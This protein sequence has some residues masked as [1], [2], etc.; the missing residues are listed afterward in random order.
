MKK[1][2]QKVKLRMRQVLLSKE[3]LTLKMM[4]VMRKVRQ[5]VKLR[6]I[7]LPWSKEKL[8]L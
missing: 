1:V 7:Q 5:K 4:K 3:K 6:M 8:L 2:M